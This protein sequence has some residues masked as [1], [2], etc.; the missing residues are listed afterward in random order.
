MITKTTA[1]QYLRCSHCGKQIIYDDY[2]L[3][4]EGLI[5]CSKQCIDDEIR[6][7]NNLDHDP[8]DYE[9]NQII[10]EDDGIRSFNWAI[11]DC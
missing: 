9:I 4:F 5:Y 8:S 3:D 7:F 10:E 11:V 2:A 1:K 6:E